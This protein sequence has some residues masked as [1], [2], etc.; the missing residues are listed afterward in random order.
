MPCSPVAVLCTAE[1]PPVTVA[2]EL[3]CRYNIS[4]LLFMQEVKVRVHLSQVVHLESVAMADK[5]ICIMV[6]QEQMNTNPPDGH[7]DALNEILIFRVKVST[8]QS[9]MKSKSTNSLCENYVREVFWTTE[10]ILSFKLERDTKRQSDRG[11]MS[12]ESTGRLRIAISGGAAHVS[13][14]LWY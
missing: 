2:T 10:N 5:S 11:H 1:P 13:E 8:F 6:G 4:S 3:S 9:H 14:L 7:L 12:A